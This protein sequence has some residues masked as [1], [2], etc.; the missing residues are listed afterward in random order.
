VSTKKNKRYKLINSL[1]FNTN[2]TRDIFIVLKQKFNKISLCNRKDI[3]DNIT[4]KHR[5][6]KN[7]YITPKPS[8]FNPFKT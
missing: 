6:D 4:I 8:V 7:T 5:F 3:L 1:P 2:D